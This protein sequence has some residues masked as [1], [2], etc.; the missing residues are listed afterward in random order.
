[1]RV[2]CIKISCKILYANLTV[3]HRLN[4]VI[5]FAGDGDSSVTKK[6]IEVLPYGINCPVVRVHKSFIVQLLQQ[7]EGNRKEIKT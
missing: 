1:M 7:A 4:T 3:G 6:L 5:S 2:S